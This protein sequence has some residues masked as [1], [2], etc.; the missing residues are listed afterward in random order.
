[1]LHIALMAVSLALLPIL[2]SPSLETVACRRPFAAHPASA[3]RHHRTA[4]HPALH[5][6]PIAASLVRRRQT[7]RHPLPPVRSFEFR[8]AARAVELSSPCR[9]G[10]HHARASLRMVGH[11]CGLRSCSARRSHGQPC[12]PAT[13]HQPRPLQRRRI[14][15]LH[16]P[17]GPTRILW[18]ALAACAS[19]LLLAITNHLSQNVAP[20]PFL[21][22]LPLAVYLLS[23]ILCFERDKVYHRGVFLPLLRHRARRR[24]LCDLRQRRQSQHRLGHPHLCR[25]AVHRLHGVPRRTRAPEAR[26][27]SPHQLLYDDFARR[28]AGRRVCRHH[29]A[30]RFSHLSRT[31]ACD[32][33]L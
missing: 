16:R 22:V 31:S 10:V 1:M 25:G 7:R 28:R 19:T 14:L 32:G 24:R 9:T 23:F 13:S 6:Q 15:T 17:P 2:P 26:S 29:R 4:L 12:A 11:L 20:I 21:W 27:A 5:H 18:T 8:I 30:A 33:G 3:G